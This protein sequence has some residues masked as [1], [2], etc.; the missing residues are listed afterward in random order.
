MAVGQTFVVCDA[1]GGTVD[2]ISYK[3]EQ[4]SPRLV[5]KEATS[6]TGGKCGSALLNQRFRRYLKQALGDR[7]W[8]DDRLVEAVN[9]FDDVRD[10]VLDWRY[11]LTFPVQKDFHTE[12]RATLNCRRS[13]E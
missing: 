10:Q 11:L 8:T 5:V 12:W 9:R 13:A 4:V 3:I 2:L 1:G 6:G 7:Y